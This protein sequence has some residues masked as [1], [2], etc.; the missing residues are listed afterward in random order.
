MTV[1]A[2][3]YQTRGLEEVW[4]AAEAGQRRIVLNSPTGA[5]KT[6]MAVWL[7]EEA[8]RRHWPVLLLTHR[9]MLLEQTAAVLREAGLRFG[10]R[11]AGHKP[12]LLEDIQLAM[13][14]TETVRTHKKRAWP[15][16]PA[17]L[18][19]V[20]ECHINVSPM[21]DVVLRS[22]LAVAGSLGVGLSATPAGLSP[23]WTHLVTAGCNSELRDEGM[24]VP[25]RHYG[26]DEPDAKL[27]KEVNNG[28]GEFTPA[29][30]R[31]AIMTRSI[32]GR[33]YEWWLRLNP[34][35]KPAILFAPDVPGSIYF[36]EEFTKMGVKAAHIDGDN[37]W[38]DG[39]TVKSS[40]EVRDEIA[41][42][43]LEGNIKVVCN[44]FVLREGINWPWLYHGILATVF[45]S[46]NSYIQSG[47]RLL[48][49]YEDL[50]RVIIQDHGG[51]WWRHGSLN[52]DRTW[53]LETRVSEYRARRMDDLRESRLK[54]PLRCPKCGQIRMAG[55]MCV[56]GHITTKQ[57]RPVV[58][59]NGEL[60]WMSG[61]IVKP[62]RRKLRSGD[63]ERWRR[64]YFRAKR[65]GMNFRQAE[66]LFALENGWRW[67]VR[68][69]P[70]MPRRPIDWARR[71]IEV[72]SS[73]LL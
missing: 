68:N 22:Q 59:I 61:R 12:A 16:H 48:R 47:G 1:V 2:K 56:C 30:V 10:L 3:G 35:A 58:Q 57:S 36:A 67:P 51:N 8:Q 11:A 31:K 25:A 44:R 24:L 73:D 20:D 4:E 72:D 65:A 52:D 33:V 62:R 46:L 18:V 13:I 40:Q 66:A 43:S 39:H 53:D 38:L 21:M 54:E 14:Q 23:M 55:P 7:I 41:R 49:A 63:E 5:G 34:D 60:K 71:V 6:L 70:L 37:C 15:V 45:G 9:K 26:P 28:N 42:R 29:S 64:M 32:F 27:L 50:S 17:K 69:L 19:I